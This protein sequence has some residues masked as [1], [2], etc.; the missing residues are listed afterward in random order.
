M[1]AMSN[2]ALAVGAGE[3]ALVWFPAVGDTASSFG[4]TAL[5]LANRMR[6]HLRVLAF[7]PPGYAPGSRGPIPSFS[8]LYDWAAALMDSLGRADAPLLLSGN[9]S[10][11]DLALAAAVRSNARVAGCLF[12]SWPDWR[13]G[14]A[15]TSVDLCPRDTEQLEMLLGRSW[16]RPPALAHD[17]RH[18][19]VARFTD[20]RYRRHVDSF[21]PVE[22]GQMLDQ[23]GV[24]LEFVGGQSD[25]LVPSALL[26]ES[27]EAHRCPVSVIEDAGH[28]PQVERPRELA[29]V[30]AASARRWVRRYQETT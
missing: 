22:H 6:G 17:Q 25:Q 7:D 20:E 15:P 23:L 8:F 27:A 21:D 10:G 30:I 19:L 12:V 13:L 4:R 16:H 29:D 24:P 5:R 1:D 14:H 26:I 18:R 3:A 2:A 28:Y 11:A 9:S